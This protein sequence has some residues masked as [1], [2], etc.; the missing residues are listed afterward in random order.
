[1][2][3][4]AASERLL[5]IGLH[6]VCQHCKMSLQQLLIT[7]SG[8]PCVEQPGYKGVEHDH[9]VNDTFVHQ[10]PAGPK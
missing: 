3:R 8:E 4:L 6:A 7:N 2:D 9:K 10:L 1:M 5:V